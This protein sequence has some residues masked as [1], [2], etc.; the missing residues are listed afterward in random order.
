METP[1]PSRNWWAH[2]IVFGFV[3]LF[4]LN[5]WLIWYSHVNADTIVPSYSQEHR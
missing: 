1:P 4:V 2:S 3:C 5:G